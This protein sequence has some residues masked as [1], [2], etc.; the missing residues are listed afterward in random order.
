MLRWRPAWCS[1]LKMCLGTEGPVRVPA[2]SGRLK[3][4]VN[5]ESWEGYVDD[6][7]PYSEDTKEEE[8]DAVRGHWNQRLGAFQKLILIKSFMEE[9]VGELSHA[10]SGPLYP[11][12]F[13]FLF[14]RTN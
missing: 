7:P 12:S 11:P 5:P 2:C 6:L 13:S 10:Q 9:K 14:L 8:S 1:K 4:S 3:V